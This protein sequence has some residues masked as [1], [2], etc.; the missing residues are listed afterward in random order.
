MSFCPFMS[1]PNGI[2]STMDKLYPCINSCELHTDK[3][4]S[5]KLLAKVQTQIANTLNENDKS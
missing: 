2:D 1:K 3:G 5:L 4:C